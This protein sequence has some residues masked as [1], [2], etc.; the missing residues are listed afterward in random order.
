MTVALGN[1]IVVIIAEG[2]FVENQVNEYYLF[3]G[4]LGAATIAFGVLTFFY[5]YKDEQDN[6]VGEEKQPGVDGVANVAFSKNSIDT[7]IKLLKLNS[8]ET[9]EKI[10]KL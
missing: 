1:L 8:L 7:D 3:A 4:L 10:A 5:K 6:Q 2:K 9:K